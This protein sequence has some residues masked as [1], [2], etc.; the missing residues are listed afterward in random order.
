[1]KILDYHSPATPFT[2]YII[3][4]YISIYFKYAY[5]LPHFIAQGYRAMNMNMNMDTFREVIEFLFDNLG[6]NQESFIG[7]M[8]SAYEENK[9]TYP[10]EAN[11]VD[12]TLL[13]DRQIDLVA[14]QTTNIRIMKQLL[15]YKKDL[16]FYGLMRN[17]NIPAKMI[18]QLI[19]R[20][21]WVADCLISRKYP[22]NEQHIEIIAKKYPDL[23][24]RWLS[25]IDAD[26]TLIERYLPY[27]DS[28][29]IYVYTVADKLPQY[30][31]EYAITQKNNLMV[32]GVI[33]ASP[34]ITF[35][36]K[37]LDMICRDKE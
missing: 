25:I 2:I 23:L 32:N 34:N 13:T 31:H 21:E 30:F 6:I 12:I 9:K 8:L 10:N 35:I 20:S 26:Q 29:K 5:K 22:F 15:K 18:S 17:P 27:V 11:D 4:D 33:S 1:M 16:S 28:E 14:C 37:H 3:G 7:Y 19:K 36:V 24:T